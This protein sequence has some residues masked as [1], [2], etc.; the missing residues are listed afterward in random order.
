MEARDWRRFNSGREPAPL[1]REGRKK[2]W[3]SCMGPATT[4]IEKYTRR[5]RT[6]RTNNEL[7]QRFERTTFP[8]RLR[9]QYLYRRDEIPGRSSQLSD[10]LEDLSSARTA[11]PRTCSRCG[12][13]RRSFGSLDR[14]AMRIAPGFF[15]SG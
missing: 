1:R 2:M 12:S 13:A 5:A 6:T 8:G 7:F 3:S 9:D 15:P 10:V 11:W 14:F 4:S